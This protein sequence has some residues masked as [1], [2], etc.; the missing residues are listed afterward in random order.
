MPMS[1]PAQKVPASDAGPATIHHFINGRIVEDRDARTLPVYNPASGEQ[2]G[3]VALAS[4]ERVREAIAAAAAAQPAW[5][6]V[7]P[8]KRARVMF[9]FRHLIERHADELAR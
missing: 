9:R 7:P 2:T 8:L 5:A 1:T 6:A 4:A 3:A